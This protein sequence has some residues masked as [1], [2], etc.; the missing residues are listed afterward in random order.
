MNSISMLSSQSSIATTGASS[1][2]SIVAGRAGRLFVRAQQ[3]WVTE[4]G[5]ARL[6]V[7]TT[8]VHQLRD[9]NGVRPLRKAEF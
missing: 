5:G 2:G 3:Q 6:S 9:V 7:H 4:K 8:S 1:R